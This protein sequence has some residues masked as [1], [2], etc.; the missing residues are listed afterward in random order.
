MNSFFSSWKNQQKKELDHQWSRQFFRAVNKGKKSIQKNKSAVN[1]FYRMKKEN[2][3]LLKRSANKKLN[4]QQIK[5]ADKISNG[6]KQSRLKFIPT[7]DI[8]CKETWWSYSRKLLLKNPWQKQ[9]LE[10][11]HVLW[12]NDQTKKTELHA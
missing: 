5:L 7:K 1:K 3:I 11:Y 8:K 2:L 9:I 10:D 12:H 6:N 4:N